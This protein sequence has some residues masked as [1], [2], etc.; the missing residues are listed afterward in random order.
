MERS[1]RAKSGSK[2]RLADA[3]FGGFH[4]PSYQGLH[5]PFLGIPEGQCVVTEAAQHAAGDQVAAGPADPT[6]SPPA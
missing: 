4:R 1:P 5:L 6:G 2:A 3:R